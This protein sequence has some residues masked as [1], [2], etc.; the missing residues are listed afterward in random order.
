MSSSTKIS[1]LFF[2]FDKILV[3]IVT[4]GVGVQSRPSAAPPDGVWVS[5]YQI[6][7]TPNFT[8]AITAVSTIVF[9]YAGTPSF[10][11]IV[12]EMR[13]PRLYTRSLLFCQSVVTGVYVF[14]GCMVYYYCGSYVSSPALGSAGPTMKK[15]SYGFA[16]PGLIV[17]T[18]LLIHVSLS[19]CNGD[20]QT[21]NRAIAT[22]EVHFSP[23]FE[24]FSASYGEHRD[25]L[26]D[27]DQLYLYNC[28]GLLY[29]CEC[30]SG[31]Q[32]SRVTCGCF[33]RYS[34]VVPTYGVHVAIR[35]LDPTQDREI[36]QM[37]VDGLL[38]C[39]CDSVRNFLDDRWHLWLHCQYH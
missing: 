24:G 31:I 4:I 6:A 19:W 20:Y 28:Y 14:I 8:D 18:M 2:V 12:S 33:T 1:R 17:S 35:Q 25:S 13:D 23:S 22:I 15:I 5:D 7:A 34:Y 39:L 11:S 21:I 16:L 27:L 9:A 32:W 10:F 37:E 29:Y 30:Y 38:E 36:T 3:L 26:D